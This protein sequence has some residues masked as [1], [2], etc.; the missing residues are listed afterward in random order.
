MPVSARPRCSVWPCKNQAGRR[1][2]K[3]DAHAREDDRRRGSARERGYDADWDRCRDAFLEAHP[4][5]DD[6]GELATEVDHEISVRD[7]PEL[8]LD[9]TNLRPKCK[10][11]HSRKTVARDG[12][13]GRPKV[14]QR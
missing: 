13:F 4:L 8:R 6:C 10:K 14:R 7:A 3:C 11:H 1:G 2:G 12:G 5:C 9:W